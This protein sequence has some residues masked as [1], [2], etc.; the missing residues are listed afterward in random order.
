MEVDMARVRATASNYVPPGSSRVLVSG[1]CRVHGI[2]AT[3]LS[4]TPGLFTLYDN[5][6]AS[7]TVLLAGNVST[8]APLVILLPEM[9]A[10]ACATGLAATADANCRVFLILEY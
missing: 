2:L 7:G 10:L 6:A 1:A 9:E 3:G 5:T 4:T 8:Y